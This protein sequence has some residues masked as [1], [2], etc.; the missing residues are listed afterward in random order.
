M[1]KE[2]KVLGF[3]RVGVK[4]NLRIDEVW[5][6]GL[7]MWHHL[8]VGTEMGK[9]VVKAKRE[10]RTPVNSVRTDRMRARLLEKIAEGKSFQGAAKECGISRSAFNA[11]KNDDEEFM[12]ELMIAYEAGTEE[13]EDVAHKRAVHGEEVPITYR[14]RPV[15]DKQGK[16]L[17]RR[18]VD[19][20]LLEFLIKKRRGLIGNVK[21]TGA[22]GGPVKHLHLHTTL[23]QAFK[24]A[25]QLGILPAEIIDL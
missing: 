23:E 9:A 18:E 19:N 15:I 2:A 7:I 8:T 10:R 17:T 6:I 25:K 24:E 21:I 22:D 4:K 13:L 5:G 11:W 20:S 3:S 1:P 12:Q 14:G 16:T